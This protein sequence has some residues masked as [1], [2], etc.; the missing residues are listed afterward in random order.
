M[1][2]IVGIGTL[3]ESDKNIFEV[4]AIR[5]KRV[6]DSRGNSTVEAV[7]MAQEARSGEIMSFSAREIEDAFVT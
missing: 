7:V 2:P 1:R 6:L 5:S 3:I 4:Q